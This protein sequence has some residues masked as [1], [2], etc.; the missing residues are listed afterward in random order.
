MKAVV[1]TVS[2]YINE[3]GNIIPAPRGIALEKQLTHSIIVS[4]KPPE[5]PASDQEEE[6]TAYHVYADGQFRTSV[7]G[8]EKCRALVDNIDASKK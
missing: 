1:K 7:G 2:S 5:F 8:H 3:C 6:V 4:W